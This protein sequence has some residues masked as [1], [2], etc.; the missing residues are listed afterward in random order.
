MLLGIAI[1]AGELPNSFVKRRLGI[2]PGE[3]RRSA[4]GIVISLVDQADWV[5]V[6]SVLL[7]PVWR[8][9]GRDI[10][11]VA[12]WVTVIHIPINVVGYLIGARTAPI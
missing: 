2:P 4:L 9:S 6:A 7:R 8:M 5:P 12:A 1:W 11:E 3:Q 10:A